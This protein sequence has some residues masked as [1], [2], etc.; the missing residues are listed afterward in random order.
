MASLQR[1]MSGSTISSTS[2]GRERCDSN[3]SNSSNSACWDTDNSAS[4]NTHF[5]SPPKVCDDMDDIDA[6]IEKPNQQTTQDTHSSP[7]E[8]TQ[9]VSGGERET[10]IS[11]DTPDLMQKK[12]TCPDHNGNVAI[13][14]QNGFNDSDNTTDCGASPSFIKEMLDCEAFTGDVIRFDVRVA[15]S[16]EPD[17][18]WLH[19]EDEV[20]EDR[21]HIVDVSDNG[22]C[23]L[24]IRNVTE[25][26]EGEYSCIAV[27]DI[28]EASCSAELIVC[29]IG[30]I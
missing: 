18:H 8:I 15:G 20:Q 28:G 29:S 2:S 19:E 16:P 3:A 25:A 7:R 5:S 6:M 10:T 22:Q 24:I 12:K 17:F 4:D 11:T 30:A 21:R 1:L 13:S 14:K 23:S 26:D 9:E 27:N